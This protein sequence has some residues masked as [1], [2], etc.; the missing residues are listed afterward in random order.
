M[1]LQPHLSIDAET[2]TGALSQLFADK[3]AKGKG[4][5]VLAFDPEK[6]EHDIARL[7]LTLVEFVRQL[8]EMQAV[9]R[10]EAGKLSPE[11][12]EQLGLTLMKARE[13]IVELAAKF[14]LNPEDLSL[15]L[16]PLGRMM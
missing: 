5:A 12:E 16:G 2:V 1:S 8:L 4:D 7:V 3:I 13:R 15:D 11:E 14:S 6:V 9:R 10:M